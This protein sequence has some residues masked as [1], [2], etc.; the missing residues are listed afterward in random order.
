MRRY[1]HED[2]GVPGQSSL[3]AALGTRL[4]TLPYSPPIPLARHRETGL[5]TLLLSGGVWASEKEL[6]GILGLL[7]GQAP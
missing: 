5:S 2:L 1:V 4:G 7:Q 3:T 6:Q